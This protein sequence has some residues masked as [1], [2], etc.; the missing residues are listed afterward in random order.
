MEDNEKTEVMD[1]DSF[2]EKITDELEELL[3]K[4]DMKQL[5]LLMEELNDYDVADFLAQVE[6]YFSVTTVTPS[7]PSP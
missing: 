5:R 4:R 1:F 6:I 2:H 7:S 3:E